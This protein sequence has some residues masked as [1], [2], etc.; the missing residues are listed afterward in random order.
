MPPGRAVAFSTGIPAILLKLD[1]YSTKPYAGLVAESH[2]YYEARAVTPAH[3]A[4][5]P[6]ALGVTG[7]R[8]QQEIR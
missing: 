6:D 7:G 5:R 2:R 3:G 8:A 4:Q 1:H